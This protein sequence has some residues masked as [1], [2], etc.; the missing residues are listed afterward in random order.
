MRALAIALLFPSALMAEVMPSGLDDPLASKAA[1]MAL[2]D[3]VEQVTKSPILSAI[4]LM[5]GRT[6]HRIYTPMAEMATDALN[7]N[8]DNNEIN[9][10]LI[11]S[12]C[13]E[14]FP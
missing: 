8:P 1:C 4:A 11:R 6:K 5:E 10:V 2:A 3:Q 13:R 14:V 7:Q 12:A 9:A